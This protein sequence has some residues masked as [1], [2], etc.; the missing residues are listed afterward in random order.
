MTALRLFLFTL[1]LLPWGFTLGQG[2]LTMESESLFSLRNNFDQE[3][4]SPFYEFFGANYKSND[5]TLNLN[6]NFGFFI[7]PVG[8]ADHDFDLYQ[9]NFQYDVVKDRITV[10]GGRTSD[11]VKTI[12]WATLDMASVDMH[13]LEQRLTLGGFAGKERILDIGNFKNQADLVGGHV[14]YRTQD[15]FPLHLSSKFQHKEYN[16][17]DKQDEN[18][19]S[20]GANKTI[21]T[22]WSP[23]LL[24]ASR[25][26]LSTSETQKI[27]AGVDL[28]PTINFINRW[29]VMTYKTTAQ[30]GIEDPIF[31]I[32]SRGRLNEIMGQVE[33]NWTPH[34]ISSV[35]LA[36]DD[37]LLQ[38]SIRAE[39]YRSELSFN[40][41]PEL[42]KI[43]NKYYYFK[44]YGGYVFG[45]VLS[46][47][48]QI[49]DSNEI[50]ISE[51]ITYYEKITSA[52]STAY[53]TELMF[54]HFWKNF[55]MQFGGEF[56]SNNSLTYDLRMM[57]K[58]SYLGQMERN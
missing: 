23:E 46:L 55:K 18:L 2:L 56:N 30:D 22:A 19:A 9:F 10:S 48:R 54:G 47:T 8:T 6:T 20:I 16:I 52:Q 13:F 50:F 51:D 42:Y 39:G 58:L 14:S 25:Y 4:E 32:I 17:Q 45:G 35:T 38:E 53:N 34:F 37:Y 12:G 26:N 31:S 3:L 41:R 36:Y 24:L 40:Y 29:R 11:P 49:F 33:Y 15:M 7:D 1:F 44:S 5:Q 28:Y 27:E 57:A 21:A 43:N